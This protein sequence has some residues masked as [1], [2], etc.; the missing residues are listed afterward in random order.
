[1]YIWVDL[2]HL[3]VPTLSSRQSSHSELSVTSPEASTY[4][5]CELE[6]AETCIRNG[7]MIAPGNVYNPEEF[8]WF[9]V[10]ITV[11][12]PALEEGLNR[13]WKSVMEVQARFQD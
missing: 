5:Q 3:L 10:T 8:G 6:I 9:R 12:K 13:L 2:R 11:G 4:K 1:M 7:V